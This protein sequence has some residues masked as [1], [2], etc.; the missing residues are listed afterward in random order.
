M[1][2]ISN[3]NVDHLMQTNKGADFD[4]LVRCHSAAISGESHSCKVVA[5]RDHGW[6]RVYL[7]I[8]GR[9]F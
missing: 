2:D 7:S 1:V 3:C 9:V 8:S 4:F 5:E 6:P